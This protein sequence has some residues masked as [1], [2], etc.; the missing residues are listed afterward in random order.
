MG[1]Y[2]HRAAKI[3]A[4]FDDAWAEKLKKIE[5]PQHRFSSESIFHKNV[6][7]KNLFKHQGNSYLL[8]I[9]LFS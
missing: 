2:Q 9:S 5:L 3:I 7:K 6:D 4:K 8:I 1:F